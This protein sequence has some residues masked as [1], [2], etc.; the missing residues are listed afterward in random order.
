MRGVNALLRKLGRCNFGPSMGVVSFTMRLVIKQVGM[1][2]KEKSLSA[3]YLA[4]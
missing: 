4:T 3:Y 2:G 1:G